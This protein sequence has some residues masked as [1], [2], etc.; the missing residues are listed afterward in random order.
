MRNKDGDWRRQFVKRCGSIRIWWRRKLSL[1]GD[2]VCLSVSSTL[3]S[4]HVNHRRKTPPSRLRR[5]NR[6]VATR[7]NRARSLQLSVYSTRPSRYRDRTSALHC[8]SLQINLLS[9]TVADEE[10]FRRVDRKRQEAG[11]TAHCD[12]RRFHSRGRGAKRCGCGDCTRPR[13]RCVASTAAQRRRAGLWRP[14]PFQLQRII[15]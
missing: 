9:A 12:G 6:I 11:G 2:S 5:A 4:C 8:L 13:W 14:P 7:K 15:R 1:C 10:P 3:D